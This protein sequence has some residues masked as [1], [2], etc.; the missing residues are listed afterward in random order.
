MGLK[1]VRKNYRQANDNKKLSTFRRRKKKTCYANG[2]CIKINF[3][4]VDCGLELSR[5]E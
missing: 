5:R 1:K 2:G 3:F 4:P